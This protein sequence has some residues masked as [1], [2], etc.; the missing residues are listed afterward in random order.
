MEFTLEQDLEMIKM[1]L[2]MTLAG[3]AKVQRP[4]PRIQHLQWFTMESQSLHAVDRAL[5]SSGRSPTC[6]ACDQA[7][8]YRAQDFWIYF[9]MKNSLGLGYLKEAVQTGWDDGS[10]GSILLWSPWHLP[11]G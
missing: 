10:G 3:L 2:T 9:G 8:E 11:W 5:T 6:P 4:R 7:D 1:D